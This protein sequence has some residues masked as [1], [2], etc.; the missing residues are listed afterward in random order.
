M[1][2]P[3]LFPHPN[4][5]ARKYPYFLGGLFG[6]GGIPLRTLVG[7][8]YEGSRFV[9]GGLQTSYLAV[10]RADIL[11]DEGVAFPFLVLSVGYQIVE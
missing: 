11:T 2:P 3:G 1:Q 8:D 10:Q 5:L 7:A 6:L 9:L 4:Q